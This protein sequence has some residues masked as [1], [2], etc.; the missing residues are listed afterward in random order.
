[1]SIMSQFRK[2]G[3]K[4]EAEKTILTQKNQAKMEISQKGSI[5]HEKKMADLPGRCSIFKPVNTLS[6]S[7]KIYKE[8]TDR[9]AK[10][11]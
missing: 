11:N 5:H 2:K 1:M 7:F 9:T 10:R 8:N 3:W 4:K 6:T